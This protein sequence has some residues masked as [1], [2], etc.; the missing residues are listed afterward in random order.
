VLLQL[1]WQMLGQHLHGACFCLLRLLQHTYRLMPPMF[2]RFSWLTSCAA[3]AA[4]MLLCRQSQGPSLAW[5]S[6]AIVRDADGK[7]G[8]DGQPPEHAVAWQGAPNLDHSNA[9]VRPPCYVP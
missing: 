5:G 1:G 3:A 4:A 9:Q 6:W 8:G 2:L 7:F